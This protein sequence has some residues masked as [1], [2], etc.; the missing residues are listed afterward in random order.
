MGFISERLGNVK[1]SATLAISAKAKELIAGGAD[2]VNLS[3]GEPDFDPPANIIAAAKKA[4]DKGMHRYTAVEG[5]PALRRA[6]IEKFKRDNNIAYGMYE[7][8]ASTGAKQA[9]YNAFMAT[10]NPG[11]EV[12]IPSAFWVSYPEMVTLCGGTPVLI[13]CPHKNGFKPTA[14]QLEKA[15]TPR[16][17]WLVMNYPNN[18]SGAVCSKEELSALGKVLKAYPHVHILSD[19]VY[20][21]IIYDGRKFLNIVNVCPELKDRTLV[22]NALSKSYGMTGWRL[23]YC[24]GSAE[25]IKSMNIIQSQSTSNP[26]SIVQEAAIAALTGPQE[27]LAEW[28][29]NYTMRRDYV[30]GRLNKINGLQCDFPE[31]AFYVFPSCERVVKE[32]LIKGHKFKDDIDFSQYLL[33]RCGVAVTPG[34]VFGSPM[35][36]RIS[37][38][39]SMGD[40][41]KACDRIEAV[42]KTV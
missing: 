1:P 3:G 33:E 23:G 38:A 14:E 32:N 10:L 18:P 25:L 21:Q 16:T 40:I 36:F 12:I 8:M 2:I 13:E 31:G 7:V 24:G 22:V 35:H 27:F 34:S 9:I 20:E 5:K 26:C 15:I 11:D 17:K 30:V 41:T 6:I 28:L 37:F 29:K 19:D 4:M 42:L 39:N